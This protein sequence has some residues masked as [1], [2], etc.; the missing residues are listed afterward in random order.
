MMK[1]AQFASK[2]KLDGEREGGGGQIYV[3]VLLAFLNR[4][5][6]FP[7]FYRDGEKEKK[8]FLLG[9]R[10]CCGVVRRRRRRSER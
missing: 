9:H 3:V 5:E 2:L 4:G 8:K 10:C 7:A 6:N 1:G